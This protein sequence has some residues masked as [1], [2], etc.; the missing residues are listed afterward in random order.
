MPVEKFSADAD[1]AQDETA[2]ESADEGVRN[3]RAGGGVFQRLKAPAG[4]GGAL[5]VL[6]LAYFLLIGL[7]L[8]LFV[9]ALLR[10]RG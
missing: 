9:R 7:G 8:F 3:T 10:Q 6:I 4:V 2:E 1:A 5:A